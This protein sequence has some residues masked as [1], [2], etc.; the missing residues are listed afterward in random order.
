M[1]I[2]CCLTAINNKNKGID[3]KTILNIHKN[4]RNITIVFI[5]KLLFFLKYTNSF[6]AN[7]A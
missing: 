4:N 5:F 1:K 7:I 6:K 3:G 2:L